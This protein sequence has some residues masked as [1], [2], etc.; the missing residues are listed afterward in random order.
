M[1][2]HD[3]ELSPI[4]FGDRGRSKGNLHPL[5]KPVNWAC[6]FSRHLSVFGVRFPDS[7]PPWL[8][9]VTNRLRS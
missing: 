7:W 4:Q 2:G 8:T 6:P 5:S 9:R 3:P 1:T